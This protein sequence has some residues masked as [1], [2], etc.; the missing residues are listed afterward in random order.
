MSKLELLGVS[1][2]LILS[3]AISQLPLTVYAQSQ[4]NAVKSSNTT[5]AIG[6]GLVSIATRVSVP[7]SNQTIKVVEG[8]LKSALNDFFKSGAD[9]LKASDSDLPIIKTKIV[10]QVNNAVQNVEGTEATNAIIGVEI[11]KALK[12]KTTSSNQTATVTID[13]SSICKPSDIKLISCDNSVTI[14]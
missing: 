9:V 10:N 12:S 1:V 6:N 4:S 8:M 5:S 14:K 7:I 13:T 3:I 2:V 11:N